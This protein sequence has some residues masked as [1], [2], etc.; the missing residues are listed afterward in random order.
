MKKII[1]SLVLLASYSNSAFADGP[2]NSI[3]GLEGSHLYKCSMTTHDGLLENTEPRHFKDVTFIAFS[4]KE[5]TLLF[6]NSLPAEMGSHYINNFAKSYAPEIDPQALRKA[7]DPKSF[8]ATQVFT[9][10]DIGQKAT[11][12]SIIFDYEESNNKRVFGKIKA[13]K[14]RLMK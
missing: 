2:E 14:C 3:V 1:F 7:L 10:K 5:A 8:Y 11:P 4:L 12:A 6:A 13:V 9:D